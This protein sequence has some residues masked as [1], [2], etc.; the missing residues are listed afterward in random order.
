[1]V[2]HFAVNPPAAPL[3]LEGLNVLDDAALIAHILERYHETHRREWPVL[4]ELAGKVERVHA[5]APEAPIGLAAL[6][7]EIA[8]ELEA[9]QQKEEQVLF[10][11]MLRGAPPMIRHPIARMMMEHDDVGALLR[12]MERLTG[13]L[14]EPADACGSWRRLYAGCRKFRDDLEAH[15]MLE[16]TVLFPRFLD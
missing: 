5:D 14:V 13:N 16:N 12:E 15:I 11:M 7:Q 4:I 2:A 9:H 6:L 10:P 1:M 3:S 8:A